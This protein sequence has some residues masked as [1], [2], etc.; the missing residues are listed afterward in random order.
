MGRMYRYERHFSVDEARRLLA[1]MLPKIYLYPLMT[2]V[3]LTCCAAI[4]VSWNC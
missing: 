3:T 4:A 1:E 2:S